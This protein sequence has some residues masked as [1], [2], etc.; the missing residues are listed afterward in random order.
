MLSRNELEQAIR[1]CEELPP[2][3]STSNKLA[4][5]YTLYDHL[6]GSTQSTAAPKETI[7]FYGNSEF[8]KVINGKNTTKVLQ[9]VEELSDTLQVLAPKVY[10]AFIDKLRDI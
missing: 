1:E 10:Y 9:V 3:L 6:Y 2:S 7:S 4:T 8:A 5:F